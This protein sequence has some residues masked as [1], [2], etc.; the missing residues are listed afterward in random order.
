MTVIIQVR[1]FSSNYFRILFLKITRQSIFY[2]FSPTLTIASNPIHIP[3]PARVAETGRVHLGPVLLNLVTGTTLEG[4]G[5]PAGSDV[6]RVAV[7]TADL[8]LRVRSL[9]VAGKVSASVNTGV[10]W[11]RETS[12]LI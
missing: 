7:G 4:Q 9:N 1:A 10:I 12:K 6:A 2:L 8:E 5:R 3:L 11:D